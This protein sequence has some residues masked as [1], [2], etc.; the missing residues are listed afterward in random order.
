MDAARAWLA[1]WIELQPEANLSHIRRVQ[2][3]KDPLRLAAIYEGLALAGVPEA[4]PAST[5]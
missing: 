3:A 4:T 2:P 5:G 1:R